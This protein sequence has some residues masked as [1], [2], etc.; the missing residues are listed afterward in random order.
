MNERKKERVAKTQTKT[1]R[2]RKINSRESG[3]A[4]PNKNTMMEPN[5]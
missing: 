5:R 1:K 4:I 3:N 2:D